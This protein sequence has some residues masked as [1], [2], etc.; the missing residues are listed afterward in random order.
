MS[1]ITARNPPTAESNT[2]DNPT[3]DINN[4]VITNI[5][6]NSDSNFHVP[7]YNPN[8]ITSP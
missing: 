6:N 1:K 8:T 2:I 5:N 4:I 7:L 3:I